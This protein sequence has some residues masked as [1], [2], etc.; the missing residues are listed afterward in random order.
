MRRKLL[1][2]MGL[3][4]PRKA[5]IHPGERGR[6]NSSRSTPEKKQG[7]ISQDRQIGKDGEQQAR[8]HS[9]H[10]ALGTQKGIRERRA[11][12]R[13]QAAG[14]QAVPSSM[15]A[16]RILRD[17]ILGPSITRACG[18]LA[19]RGLVRSAVTY[20]L[21]HG[22]SHIG[23]YG[24]KNSRCESRYWDSLFIGTED[25]HRSSSQANPAMCGCVAS[26]LGRRPPQA[27]FRGLALRS[28]P[29]VVESTEQPAQEVH[30]SS[31]SQGHW[32]VSC[33]PQ[34]GFDP[35]IRQGSLCSPENG[36]PFGYQIDR[37]TLH[38]SIEAHAVTSRRS[39]STTIT[40]SPSHRGRCRLSSAYLDCYFIAPRW[41]IYCDLCTVIGIAGSC[42]AGA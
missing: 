19:N 1:R 42:G 28:Q 41:L 3:I 30:R 9:R 10:L 27:R 35:N 15:V 4:V 16:R 20:L 40:L 5:E 17:R 37:E 26:D 38:R 31:W 25:W 11:E 18:N 32:P 34:N 24:I 22:S 33:H 29:T 14:A 39:A 23:G 7:A 13:A 6:G 36:W 8:G 21:Q 12:G 2:E